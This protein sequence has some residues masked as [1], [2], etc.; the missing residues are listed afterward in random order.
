MSSSS[1]PDGEDEGEEG[2]KEEEEEDEEE[3]PRYTRSVVRLGSREMVNRLRGDRGWTDL[4]IS[5]RISISISLSI[6]VK[7][8]STGIEWAR[9][10][11]D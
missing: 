8:I 7:P 11:E 2:E 3:G 4:Y 6:G 1:P 9:E 10:V 5:I